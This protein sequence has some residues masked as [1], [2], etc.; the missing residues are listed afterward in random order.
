MLVSSDSELESEKKLINY[1]E[2]YNL[3]ISQSEWKT[4]IGKSP[5]NGNEQAF[6]IPTKSRLTKK[7]LPDKRFKSPIVICRDYDEWWL[8]ENS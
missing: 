5:L 6:L 3:D 8:P 2:K 4:V 1:R 7:G